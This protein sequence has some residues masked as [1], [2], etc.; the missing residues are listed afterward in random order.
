ME[1][2]GVYSYRVFEGVEHGGVGQLGVE[3]TDHGREEVEEQQLPFLEEEEEH[4]LKNRIYTVDNK[5]KD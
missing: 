1:E 5:D 3:L 4:D 2:E